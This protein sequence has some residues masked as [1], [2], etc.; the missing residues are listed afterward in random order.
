MKKIMSMLMLL[1]LVLG[2]VSYTYAETITKEAVVSKY[3]ESSNSNVG[4]ASLEGSK[5]VIKE[6][7]EEQGEVTLMEF[8]VNGN[9]LS[10]TVNKPSRENYFE[11]LELFPIVQH[12]VESVADLK[13]YTERDRRLFLFNASNYGL[14]ING[15]TSGTPYDKN[16]I[17]IK[18]EGQIVTFK[19]N[20]DTFKIDLDY[21]EGPKP[22]IVINKVTKNEITYSAKAA[23]ESGT[24]IELY[25]STDGVNFEYI[26]SIEYQDEQNLDY[27]SDIDKEPNTT[28][29]YKAVVEK[30]SVFSDVAKV[31][32]LSNDAEANAEPVVASENEST[33]ENTPVDDKI[34][35]PKTDGEQNMIYITSGLSIIGLLFFLLHRK[36]KIY[37][38]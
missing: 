33:Q 14:L 5:I 20:L 37:N 13:G 3:N 26:I 9:E 30:S 23:V 38:I 11:A 10:T 22:E 6:S 7:N 35:N 25:R 12:L 19:L 15:F 4:K 17:S 36:N 2:N 18:L 27:Y 29:Y 34:S 28:Y 21:F 1:L 31:T 32:T 24:N 8:N 16:G